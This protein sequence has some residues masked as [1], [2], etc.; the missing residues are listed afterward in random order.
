MPPL[1][2][3][4]ENKNALITRAEEIVKAAE[5][6]KRDLSTA[7]L[8]EVNQIREKVDAAKK[9][10]EAV[11]GVSEMTREDAPA[12][13]DKKEEKEEEKTEDEKAKEAEEVRNFEA[14]VR[15]MIGI[16]GG[17]NTRDDVTPL[18]K[19][20]NGAIVPVTIAKRIIRKLYDISPILER[21]TKY[22]LPGTLTIPYYTEDATNYINV[23]FQGP[24]FA[25]IEA[26]SG[27]FTSITLN[28]Y[29][30][31]ALALVS[32]QLINNTE[33]DLV[34][35]IVDQIAYSVRRFM[36]KTLIQGSDAITGQ[37][38]TVEGLTGITQ[39]VNAGSATAITADNLIDLQDS[40]KDMFQ[41]GAMWVM[42]PKTRTAIRKLKSQTG[43]YLLQQ[44][45]N[46]PFGNTLLGKP[47]YVSD[48][49]PEIGAGNTPILYGNFAG[50]ATKFSQNLEIDVLREK[51]ATS[52]A[53]G[54]NAWLAFDSKVE[55]AQMLSKLVMANASA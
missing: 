49:M 51:Y 53:Y 20:N 9:Q 34:G 43:Y 44:D 32:R 46:A 38:G 31:G 24:E 4:I 18:S 41:D 54:I 5:D 2:K 30:V 21:S 28:D 16:G 3:L 1:K 10:I 27:K 52:Y 50:L 26:N 29:V 23:G 55:N 17:L 8:A 39:T 47:V 37:T 15:A 48:N 40:V 6:E 25:A 45:I 33:F 14:N 22:S 13:E 35:Y 12:G 19:G 7:E 11:K 42:S 36:E